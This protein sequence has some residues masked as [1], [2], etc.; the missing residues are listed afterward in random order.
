VTADL[1][2]RL[3]EPRYKSYG[4]G[5][6]AAVLDQYG[7]P[8]QYERPLLVIDRNKQRLWYADF[9][10]SDA[11]VAVEYFGLAGQ[12]EYDRSIDHKT[13]VYAENGIGMVPVHRRHLGRELPDY[14]MGGIE[15]ILQNRYERFR[16]ARC[17]HARSSRY[18]R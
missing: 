4:E 7:V 17:E 14:L 8:Y 13:Q 10:L 15:R 3:A 11:S 9:W 12:P 16:A 5:R 18:S 2:Y 1:D 6:I